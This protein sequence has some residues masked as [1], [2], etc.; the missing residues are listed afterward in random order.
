MDEILCA[1]IAGLL[2][3]DGSIILQLKPRPD[4]RYGFQIKATVAFYQKSERRKPLDWLQQQIG[5]GRVRE[6]PDGIAEYDIEGLR[7]VRAILH[8]VRE[9]VKLKK[10]Q[11]EMAL[12]L[13]EEMLANVKPTPEQFL[14]WARRV[15]SYQALNDSKRRKYTSED[16]HG[17]LC[18]MG[19][20]GPR[21]D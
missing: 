1:Y 17:F 18:R 13:I 20:L 8:L 5:L 15:E 14:E 2:D 9:H 12:S 6:R 10:Q 4:Y 21:N 16:V 7:E 11:V 3:G 19:Y